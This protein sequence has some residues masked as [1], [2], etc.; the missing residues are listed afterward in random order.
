MTSLL[1]SIIAF[2]P[3]LLASGF[4]VQAAGAQV[5]DPNLTRIPAGYREWKLI[6]VAREQGKQDDIRAVLGN[7]IA[8]KAYREGI[9]PFPDGAIIA[10]IAWNLVPSE[11]NNKAFGQEQSWV[12]GTPK[13][14]VQFMFK[15]TQKYAATGGWGYAQFGET[16]GK[17]V[18]D[19]AKLAA[20]YNCH[21]PAAAHD[22]VFTRYSLAGLAG[23][24]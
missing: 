20:C 4:L 3:A 13:N 22:F 19:A 12:A 10:R 18:V 5:E 6:S 15:D 21:K 16:D 7:D 2:S 23:E 9:I 8:I 11:E 14:G 17:P 1:H 24:K